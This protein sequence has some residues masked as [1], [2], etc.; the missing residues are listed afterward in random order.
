MKDLSKSAKEHLGRYIQQMRQCLRKCATVDADEVE[1][2]IIDHIENEL[3]SASEPVSFEKLDTVLRQLGSPQ[4]WVPEDEITWWRKVVLRLHYG[5]E[6]WRLAYI[7]FGFFL[8]WLLSGFG[9]RGCIF[10]PLGILRGQMKFVFILAGFIVSRAAI[11][12]AKDMT[13][14]AGQK[15]L[16]YPSLII[17]YIPLLFFFFWPVVSAVI[18]ATEGMTHMGL[19]WYAPYSSLYPGLTG[20]M[21]AA[22]ALG[23][24]WII[25]GIILCIAPQIV[26]FVF[27]PFAE[28]FSCKWAVLL[29]VIGSIL[30][31]ALLVVMIALP[32]LHRA[33]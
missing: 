29:I 14:L 22:G 2:N 30:I 9:L 17:V 16:L 11:S 1:R 27:R 13:K 15:W 33:F 23:L 19:P 7:S 32:I 4:Q 10:W 3:A 21:V 5:P 28:W 26:R 24:W 25:L 18:F 20:G 31:T 12:Q 6:D 8:L